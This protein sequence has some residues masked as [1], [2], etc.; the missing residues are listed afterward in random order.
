MIQICVFKQVQVDRRGLLSEL[1]DLIKD[2]KIS[3]WTLC[4]CLGGIYRQVLLLHRVHRTKFHHLNSLIFSMTEQ[5][6]KAAC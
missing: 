4:V 3:I 1:L 2:E 5:T 6:D